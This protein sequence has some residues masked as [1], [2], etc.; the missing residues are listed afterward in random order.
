VCSL[1]AAMFVLGGAP[2]AEVFIGLLIVVAAWISVATPF[3]MLLGLTKD[4]VVEG[5][6]IME[7]RRV[8]RARQADP[9]AGAVSVLTD[10]FAGGEL[11][12]LEDHGDRAT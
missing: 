7:A 11:A 2:A 8:I 1:F 9:V 3:V 6:R 5:R 12:E 10:G 4:A